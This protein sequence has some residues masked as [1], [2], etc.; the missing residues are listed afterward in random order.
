[1]KLPEDDM[2]EKALLL[3]AKKRRVIIFPESYPLSYK[4]SNQISDIR[5]SLPFVQLG[6]SDDLRELI[7]LINSWCNQLT[8]WLIWLEVLENFNEDE[9]WSLQYNFIEPIIFLCMFQ[10]SAMKDRF[11]SI[12]TTALHQASLTVKSDYEDKL[13]NDKHFLN[14][15]GAEKQLNKIGSSWVS[16]FDF[17]KLFQLLNSKEYIH[18]TKNY[19]NSASHGISPRFELGET[20]LITRS[21]VPM[22]YLEENENGTFNLKEDKSKKTIAYGFGGIEPLDMRTIYNLNMLEYNKTVSTLT[23]YENLL[24]EIIKMIELQ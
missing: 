11:I 2:L 23:A 3:F 19:R 7:N 22:T 9:Q 16:F 8:N 12:A 13:D 18:K 14:R 24:E 15:S 5:F 21:L 6:I 17:Q 10:P 20:N 4:L 1:M